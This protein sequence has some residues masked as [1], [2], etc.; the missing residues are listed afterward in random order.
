M[1]PGVSIE[2]ITTVPN[3]LIYHFDWA[4]AEDVMEMIKELVAS[5][6]SVTKVERGLDYLAVTYNIEPSTANE[7]QVILSIREGTHWKRGP[8]AD[9]WSAPTL[10]A[11][12]YHR[13]RQSALKS[14]K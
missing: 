5:L 3:L 13:K 6:D 2:S 7:F 11:S 14:A 10:E 9:R 4:L 12:A 8:V 1:M